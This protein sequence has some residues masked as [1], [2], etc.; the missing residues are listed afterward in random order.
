M[1]PN[2]TVKL[3]ELINQLDSKAPKDE[4]KVIFHQY[5]GGPDESKIIAN[6]NGY[7]R[8]GVEFLKAAFAKPSDTTDT[9]I[10]IDLDYLITE[11][12][13]I[14]FD[15]FERT[16]KVVNEEVEIDTSKTF[17]YAFFTVLTLILIAAVIGAGSI[18]NWIIS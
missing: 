18:V 3:N 14:N 4:A 7:L 5:G 6:T 15:W 17:T 2:S 16:D 9:A 11:D 8:L 1:E 13:T 10:D 12:S